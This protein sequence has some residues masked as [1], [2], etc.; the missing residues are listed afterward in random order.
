MKITIRFIFGEISLFSSLTVVD[1]R[2]RHAKKLE[3][4]FCRNLLKNP[5]FEKIQNHKGPT[6]KSIE[7]HYS[8]AAP[9]LSIIGSKITL[10][11]CSASSFHEYHVSRGSSSEERAIESSLDR[12]NEWTGNG[13]GGGG[14]RDPGPGF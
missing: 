12:K 5:V 10:L 1:S 4:H 11:P 13:G 3:K 6:L 8:S 14:L 7:Y 2:R 9:E